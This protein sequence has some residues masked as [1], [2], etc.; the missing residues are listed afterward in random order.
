MSNLI[1]LSENMTEFEKPR[2][3]LD[4]AQ[5]NLAPVT[6]KPTENLFQSEYVYSILAATHTNRKP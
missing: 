1:C 3:N 5:S 6:D 2:G 4:Y